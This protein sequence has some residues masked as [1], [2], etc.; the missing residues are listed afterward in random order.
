MTIQSCWVG[1]KAVT[2]TGERWMSYLKGQKLIY[3]VYN[4]VALN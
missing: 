4:D 2:E 3:F 1:S